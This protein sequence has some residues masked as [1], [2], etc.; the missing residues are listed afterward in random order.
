MAL[1]A[2]A[3]FNAGWNGPNGGMST[4][5]VQLPH[6]E[7][8]NAHP[9]DAR[10]LHESSKPQ[11]RAVFGKR[12]PDLA[13][14]LSSGH[15]SCTGARMLG[16]TRNCLQQHGCYITQTFVATPKMQANVYTCICKW[17]KQQELQDAPQHMTQ[18]LGEPKRLKC[19]AVGLSLAF[20]R[21][22]P[23]KGAVGKGRFDAGSTT[24]PVL[25]RGL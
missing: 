17:M 25:R 21:L 3:H 8:P 12:V 23:S 1:Q 9:L 6:K 2:S 7:L 15:M 16:S 10:L 13:S 5:Q 24:Y 19:L 18:L 11:Q 4:S 20:P 14:L 22:A